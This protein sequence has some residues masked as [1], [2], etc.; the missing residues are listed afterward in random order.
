MV[1]WG[2]WKGRNWRVLISC[3]STHP[4]LILCSKPDLLFLP[5]PWSLG[6]LGSI[7]NLSLTPELQAQALL[8]MSLKSPLKFNSAPQV[9]TMFP[10]FPPSPQTPSPPVI[11]AS[12]CIL[13]LP[14]WL[15]EAPSHFTALF[16]RPSWA[17]THTAHRL[18]A[19]RGPKA[20][21]NLRLHSTSLLAASKG[22]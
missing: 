12:F 11:W 7:F 5:F 17:F 1:W 8:L 4:F 16:R 21:G 14:A 2:F 15:P 22:S 10:K 6:K 19:L 13:L 9:I 20:P 18:E 3:Q